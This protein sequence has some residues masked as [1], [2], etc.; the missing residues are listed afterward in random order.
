MAVNMDNMKARYIYAMEQV[1]VN[2]TLLINSAPGVWD[3]HPSIRMIFRRLRPDEIAEPVEQ[4]TMV[5][6]ILA[7]EMPSGVD[8]LKTRDR[9]RT[10]EGREFTIQKGDYVNREVQGETMMVEALVKG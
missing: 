9:I 10:D 7:S 4:G 5:A 1:G 2:C 6:M 8:K 3:E